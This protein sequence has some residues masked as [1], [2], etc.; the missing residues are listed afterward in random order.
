MRI[1]R[2]KFLLGSSAVAAAP[3]ALTAAGTT[4]LVSI[5]MDLEMARNY[6]TW[7]QTEW[8]YEKGNLSP[9]VKDYA[10]KAARRVTD[11]V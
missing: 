11:T 2:R 5:S 3:R 7:D 1:S 4:A 9:A 6:P 8:D 10:L